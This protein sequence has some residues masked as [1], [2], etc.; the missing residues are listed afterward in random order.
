LSDQ[1]TGKEER[2]EDRLL[3]GRDFE[4]ANAVRGPY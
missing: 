4:T 3:H 2:N 1:D